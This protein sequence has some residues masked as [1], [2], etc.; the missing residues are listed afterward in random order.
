MASLRARSDDA[1]GTAAKE[2]KRKNP[3]KKISSDSSPG[4]FVHRWTAF[5]DF[6]I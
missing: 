3:T 1:P 2:K 6:G 5:F 4:E